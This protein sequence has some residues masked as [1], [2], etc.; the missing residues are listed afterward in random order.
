MI[1]QRIKEAV[2]VGYDKAD[3][4]LLYDLYEEV[5]NSKLC[6]TCDNDSILA[7]IKLSR[8]IMRKKKV[9]KYIFNPERK[10]EK[11]VISSKGWKITADNYTQDQANY[12]MYIGSWGDLF[13]PEPKKAKK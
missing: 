6:R 8:Y 10:A 7:F 12:V 9:A 3:K 11:V 4:N 1:D 5:F 2:G 13:I